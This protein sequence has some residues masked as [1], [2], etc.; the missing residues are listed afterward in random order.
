ML[1]CVKLKKFNLE[2]LVSLFTLL[3]FYK[4][5]C[6]F[7]NNNEHTNAR[8]IKFFLFL[9]QF[10]SFTKN[11]DFCS[12]FR[13]SS[14]SILKFQFEFFSH[15]ELEILVVK[16]NLSGV[17]KVKIVNFKYITQVLCFF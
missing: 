4:N 1:Q 8:F 3:F 2:N 9:R 16:N 15:I 17:Y 7:V 6:L 14:E 13:L 11:K 10:F 5:K 12:F